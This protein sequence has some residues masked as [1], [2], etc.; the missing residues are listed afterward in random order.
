MVEVRLTSGRSLTESL[1]LLEKSMRGG[2]PL[3]PGFAGLLGEEVERGNIVVLAAYLDGAV[4]GV[5]VLAFRPSISVAGRFASIEELYVEPKARRRGVGQALLEAVQE[6]C[7]VNGVSYV[8]V[9]STDEDAVRFY[10]ASGYDVE[11]EVRTLSRSV[12]LEESG[13]WG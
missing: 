3:P 8:E 1:T 7:A 4:L 12:A 5:A 11:S 10:R 6:Q 13:G 9:Q 2:E